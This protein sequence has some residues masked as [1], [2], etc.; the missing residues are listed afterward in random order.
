MNDESA[1]MPFWAKCAMTPRDWKNQKRI[2]WTVGTW[3]VCFLGATFAIKKGLLPAGPLSWA[4]A[5]LP[6]V[7]A[8]F[9]LMAY[10]R[11]IRETDELQR[12]VQLQALGLGF[13]AGWVAITGYPLLERLGAPAIDVGDYV[14]VMAVSYA[15]GTVIAWRRYQ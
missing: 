15:L 3:A 10:T 2:L 8:V 13:A 11:F 9:V 5:L 4:A 7:V 1:G 14:V 12:H 6:T